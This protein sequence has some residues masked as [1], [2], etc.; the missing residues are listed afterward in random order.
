MTFEIPSGKLIATAVSNKAFN[1]VSLGEN[2]KEQGIRIERAHFDTKKLSLVLDTQN[3]VWNVLLLGSDEGT[4]LKRVTA[5]QWFR[6]EQGQQIRI[7]PPYTGKWYP[8]IAVLDGSMQIVSSIR[9]M[10]VKDELQF[11]LPAGS[12]YLKVSNAQ[13]MKVLKEGMWIESLSPGR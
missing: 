6:V 5:P 7:E 8:D 3:A 13:G 10:E 4:E 9:S 2:L 11:E 1:P 12:Y